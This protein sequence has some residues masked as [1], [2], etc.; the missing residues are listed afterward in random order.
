MPLVLGVTGNIACGKSLVGKYLSELG[1][2]VLDSDEVVHQLYASDLNVQQKLL[3]EFGTCS[4]DEIAKQVFLAGAE[5]KRKKLEE[6]IHPPV[7][8]IFEN[9]VIEHSKAPVIANLVPLL[10]EAKLEG[11]YDK[12]LVIATSPEL[13]LARLS[14][15]QPELSQEALEQRIKSQ[16][17]QYEK[18][19]RADY[20]ID[21]SG[22]EAD[23]RLQI[24]D[25]IEK[26]R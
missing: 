21:N 13:Q 12:I 23:L 11:R 2:P 16:M 19:S 5:A 22:S 4:R 17:P 7:A 8:K 1:V 24:K 18:A 6:I 15:R 25:L 20:L 9:W 3:A 26:L 10:Y 14:A